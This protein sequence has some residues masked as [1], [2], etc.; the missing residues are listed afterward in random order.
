LLAAPPVTE[1]KLLELAVAWTGLPA[2][3]A[4]MA[5]RLRLFVITWDPLERLAAR[6]DGFATVNAD[7]SGVELVV[8]LPVWSVVGLA[9]GQGGTVAAV[10]AAMAGSA[11]VTAAAHEQ[12]FVSGRGADMRLAASDLLSDPAAGSA[13]G[14][15]EVR[16]VSPGWEDIGLGAIT[17]IVQHAFG[18]VD[19]D[20]STVELAAVAGSRSGC[21]ACGGRRFGFPGELAEARAVMCPAHRGQAEAVIGTRL[22]RAHASNPDGWG[23][24]GD[25]VGRLELPHLPNG[26]ATRLAGAEQA[27]YVIAEPEE[28]AERARLVVEAAGWFGGRR[29]EFAVALGVEPLLAGMLPDWLVGLVLD[30]GRAGLG[31]EAVMV[32]DALARVDPDLRAFLDGDVAV[33]LAQAG[34]A[35]QARARVESN[36]ARWPADFWIRVHAGD[37]LAVLGDL[38]GAAAHFDAALTMAEESDDFEAR[39][40]AV[41]RLRQIDQHRPNRQRRAPTGRPRRQAGRRGA[42]RRKRKR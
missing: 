7:A 24:L 5:E 35:E 36:L 31:A 37:A 19:L 17:D 6:P 13:L 2:A 14:V 1:K 21:P 18:P 12:S 33:A 10:L 29:D 27:M 16:L 30:L 42:S 15:P 41:E 4:R 40:D 9:A 28:L 39:A 34:L 3:Q 32:G 8:Y 23:A 22:E 38:D 26:L 20:R 11:V 25:A